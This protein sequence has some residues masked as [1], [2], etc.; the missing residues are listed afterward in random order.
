M[1]YILFYYNQNNVGICIIYMHMIKKMIK[2]DPLI[3][4]RYID[5]N[6]SH[7]YDCFYIIHIFYYTYSLL[8]CMDIHYIMSNLSYT[9]IL[10][11]IHIH[12]YQH[13]NTNF[14]D[15]QPFDILL[16]YYYICTHSHIF[17]KL[18][19]I[20]QNSEDRDN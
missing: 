3:C 5:E 1:I 19:S 18:Y 15:N 11:D 9:Q 17:Y 20:N 16:Y 12:F 7:R 13:Y 10:K 2:T 8:V 14:L 4:R 6:I